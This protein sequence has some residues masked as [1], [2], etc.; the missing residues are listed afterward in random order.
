[1]TVSA[2]TVGDKSS[3]SVLSHVA[4]EAGS[5]SSA[6]GMEGMANSYVEVGDRNIVSGGSESG[7]IG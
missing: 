3:G 7:A 4:D 2:E 5:L 1:M 6:S